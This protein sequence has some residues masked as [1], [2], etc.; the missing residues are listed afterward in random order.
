MLQKWKHYLAYKP[1]AV[2]TLS[3]EGGGFVRA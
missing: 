3:V 2:R 1:L